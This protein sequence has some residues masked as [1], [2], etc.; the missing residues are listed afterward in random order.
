MS[1][2]TE[3]VNS[4]SEFFPLANA[5]RLLTPAAT[6]INRDRLLFNAGSAAVAL[7]LPW[8]WPSCAIFFAGLCVVL[9]GFLFFPV[10][11]TVIER[12]RIVEVR[13]PV[14]VSPPALEPPREPIP[15]KIDGSPREDQSPSPD[16][17]RMFQVRR[18][19]LRW[20]VEMLPAS[21]TSTVPT[22]RDTAADLDRWLEVPAGTFA[23]PYQKTARQ[24]PNILG[25]D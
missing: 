3:P 11:P 19:V 22:R 6:A 16:A 12:E 18:D 13:I 20:G 21:K 7:K 24:F 4:P 9:A 14:P 2:N 8:L 25:D 23:A 1:E 5:L 17:I 10:H 15:A